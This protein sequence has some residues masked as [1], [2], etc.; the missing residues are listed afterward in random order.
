MS[1]AILGVNAYHGDASAALLVDGACVAA[2]EEERFT[3][4][5]HQAGFPDHAIRWC[6]E[7]A[8]LS[9]SDLG[10]IAIGRNPASNAKN[11]IKW[12]LFHPPDP[13]FFRDRYRNATRILDVGDAV[14]G[15]L[16]VDR[17]KMKWE[18]H[19]V[20]HHRSHLG[21]A[22][23]CSPF[24]EA[25]CISIDGMGD[26]SSTMWGLGEGRDIKMLG[27]VSHPH[28]LGHYYTMFSQFMGLPR[29]GDEYKLMGLAAYGE[30]TM[31]DKVREV[32]WLTKGLQFK[33]GL[34]YFLHHT[35][36]VAMTWEGTPEVG[37]LY[38]PR[39]FELLGPPRE[40]GAEITERDADLAASIQA[41]LEEV[42]LEMIRRLHEATKT[43]RLVMAGGVA[44]NCVLNGK[45]P[46][47]T[48]F[49]EVWVQPASNDAGTALGA[50]LW[51]RHHDL[52]RPRTW[53]MDHTYFGPGYEDADHKKA[54][55]D[56]G[57]EYRSLA[58][59]ELFDHVAQR[60][61]EGAVVGWFQGRMEFGP[62]AL[63]NRSIVCDSRRHDMKDILNARIK[64]REPFRPFAPSVLA[65][66]TGD[67]FEQDHPSPYMLMAYNVRPEKR[68]VI[69]A[70]TH[71]DGT[72]RLQTVTRDSNVRY[73]D[74]IKAFEKRTGVPVVL[75]T[76]FNENEP[77]CCTPEEAVRCFKRTHMDTLV[78]GNYVSE[79]PAG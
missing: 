1:E 52:E 16:D 57:L 67:W 65:D 14:A 55:E 64:H 66:K 36:G 32:L 62:R 76:S 9:P 15:A 24:D 47:E 74:L 10:H 44:L 31:V 63:G 59:V 50:A 56:S 18:T 33:L 23:Q 70:V 13:R 41:V 34:K 2:A 48:P 49:E 77:I 69:P 45:I 60:L 25:A 12:M 43:P 35:K 40:V 53:T 73:Y 6:L 38:S 22:F 5:K 39:I 17:K 72:G 79:K 58:D 3:R 54:L 11:K 75:N 42:G 78:L 21:S 29:Y 30:P 20:E 8:G 19:R 71:E 27:S 51:A 61:D 26:F 46:V 68:S 7:E 4:V 28:S 37:A